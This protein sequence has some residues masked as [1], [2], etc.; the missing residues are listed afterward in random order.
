MPRGAG[1]IAPRGYAGLAAARSRPASAST[2]AVRFVAGLTTLASMSSANE[3]NAAP[4][5][6]R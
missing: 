1:M 4:P 6:E 3:S 2:S 5:G